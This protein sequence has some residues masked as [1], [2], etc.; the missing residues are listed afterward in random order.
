MVATGIP[1]PERPS[2]T[3]SVKGKILFPCRNIHCINF[4]LDVGS[5]TPNTA[6]EVFPLEINVPHISE[7]KINVTSSSLGVNQYLPASSCSEGQPNCAV[8]QRSAA[9]RV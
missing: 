9:A 7:A 6:K 1:S 5:A 2:N 3:E 4:F 8:G